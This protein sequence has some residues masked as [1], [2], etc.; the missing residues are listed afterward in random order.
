MPSTYL[1]NTRSLAYPYNIMDNSSPVLRAVIFD[2]DGVLVD[3]E[4]LHFAAFKKVL[5][6]AGASFTQEV[7]N[8]QYLAMDDRGAFRTFYEQA[9]KALGEDELKKLM[10]QKTQA[11]Q[12]LVASEGLLP[13]P[14]VPEFVMAVSQRYPLAVASGARRHEV[15]MILET[16]GIRPYFEAVIT[17][18]DVVNG[19]PHPESYIKAV[20]ALNAS[21]KRPTAIRP[22]ECL[23]IEDSKHGIAA[24]HAAGMKC[25]AVATSYPA[26]EL[27]IADLVVPSISALRMSQLEDLFHNTPKPLPVSAPQSN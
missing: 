12:D 20:E 14:A 17:S 25:I 22:E 21:G 2:C 7:Y 24:A 11:Y 18:D 9:G 1:K 3:S 19:K 15:E 23:V 8:D 5:G 6:A 26:F 4:P 10:D 27:K 13:Y 16:S